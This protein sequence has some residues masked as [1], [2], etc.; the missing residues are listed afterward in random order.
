[1]EHIVQG[2]SV[3]EAA[4]IAGYSC[5]QAASNALRAMRPQLADALVKN[6]W[7]P[8]DFVKKHLIPL[9]K[10]KKTLLA[11]HEGIF[12]DKR[13]VT[14]NAVRLSAGD[15]YLKILGAYAPLSVEHSGVVEY[16][17]TEREKLEAEA[18]LKTILAED[19]VGENP[20][21]GEFVEEEAPRSER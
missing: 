13:T 11:Q 4:K 9:L 7:G 15:Q 6:G 10:A 14:D 16:V 17:L 19:S 21:L 2:K 5:I 8:E 3:T 12:T 20:L 18:T 1:M